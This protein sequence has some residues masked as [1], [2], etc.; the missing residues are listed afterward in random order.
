MVK[1][2]S[3]QLAI[4]QGDD[5]SDQPDL[6]PGQGDPAP[7]Q[8]AAEDIGYTV[9]LWAWKDQYRCKQCD[10]DTLN[11]DVMLDHLVQA[12]AVFQFAEPMPAS[13]SATTTPAP[14]AS[15]AERADGIFEIDLKED[16]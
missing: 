10:F 14:S 2:K 15:D 3:Q 4:P 5:V 6:K 13:T 1:K 7:T 12:H 16:Q 11:L 9:G 8:P